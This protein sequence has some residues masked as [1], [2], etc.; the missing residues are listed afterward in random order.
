MPGSDPTIPIPC[1][2]S[3]MSGGFIVFGKA[4][5]ALPLFEGV[6]RRMEASLGPDHPSTL[7]VKLTL[8][9]TYR[10]IG[11]LDQALPLLEEVSRRMKVKLGPDNPFTSKAVLMLAMTSRDTGRVNQALP[12][13]EEI[14]SRRK[15]KLGAGHLETRLAE[16]QFVRLTSTRGAG[17]GRGRGTRVPRIHHPHAAGRL[18]AFPRHE[19]ARRGAGRAE[20]VHR[21]RAAAAPRLR[22]LSASGSDS[23]VVA[24][25]TGRRRGS[26]RGVLRGLASGAGI[27]VESE[28]WPDRLP[29]AVF[30]GP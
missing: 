28:A 27:V 23:G 30:A 7:I 24:Q 21:R 16:C 13:L 2:L 29:A 11:R 8:A 6:S 5:A 26:D 19:P 10:D 3:S 15:A 25:D 9:Q 14:V 12:L 18:A 1:P 20:E 17:R 22:G 4:K